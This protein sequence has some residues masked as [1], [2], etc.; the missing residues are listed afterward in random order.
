MV[1][2]RDGM[3]Q[4]AGLSVVAT[5]AACSSVDAPEQHDAASLGIIVSEALGPPRPAA[6]RVS[7]SLA[8]GGIDGNVAYV[9]LPP[10]AFPS[11]ETVTITNLATG[12]ARTETMVDGGFDPVPIPAA[13]GDTLEITMVDVEGIIVSAVSEVPAR[14]PPIVV[15][16]EPAKKKTTVP[17]NV[18]LLVVFSEPID[19]ATITSETIKL[20]LDGEPVGGSV[21]LGVDGLQAEFTPAEVLARQRTYTLVIMTGIAD[22]AG[23]PL[24]EQVEVTFTI[25]LEGV[26]AF[27]RFGGGAGIE[28]SYIYRLDLDGSG[29]VRLAPGGAP[30]WSPD[31]SKIAFSRYSDDGIYVMNADGRGAVKLTD[32]GVTWSGPAWSPDGLKIAYTANDGGFD[33]NVYVINADGSAETRLTRSQALDCCPTWSPDGSK[34]AFGSDREGTDPNGWGNIYVM[35]AD[36][37]DVVRLSDDLGAGGPV[38]SPDGSKI[39]FE[40]ARDGNREIYVMNADGTGAVNLTNDPAARDRGPAWSPDGTKIVFSSWRG[41]AFQFSPPLD[42]YVMNADGSGVLRITASDEWWDFQPHWRP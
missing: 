8:G 2:F 1:R 9:S 6:A 13:V 42:I 34:I 27:M 15:R 28:S 12:A 4:F 3:V 7:G 5:L 39:A 23:D 41:R 36:G 24:E 31:G 21:T 35:N 20:L 14:K 17:L 33:W 26:I 29:L 22:L 25:A 32:R 30:A 16:T 37:S 19:P 10:G 38:W 18:R 11:G 40:T